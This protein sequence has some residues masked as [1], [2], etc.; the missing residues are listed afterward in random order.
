MQHFGQAFVIGGWR[1]QTDEVETRSLCRDA[2]LVV[3]LGWQINN[4]QPVDACRF[5]LFQ[6]QVHT[7]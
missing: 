3:F 5:G 1:R 2:K 4:D 7:T 6:K